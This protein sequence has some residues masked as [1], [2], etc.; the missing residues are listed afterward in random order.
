MSF[1]TT[2]Q[3]VL[4]APVTDGESTL[5]HRSRNLDYVFDDPAHGE[6]GRD[7]ML[8]ARRVGV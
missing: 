4:A 1:E 7:R 8:V 2:S 3:P 5:T 6:P